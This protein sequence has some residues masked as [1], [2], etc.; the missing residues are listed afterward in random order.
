MPFMN[1][2]FDFGNTIA[3]LRRTYGMTYS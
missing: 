3:D 1:Y 2:I